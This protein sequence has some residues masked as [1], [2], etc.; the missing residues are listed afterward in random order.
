MKFLLRRRLRAELEN[1]A[2]I[3]RA[4]SSFPPV[5]VGAFKYYEVLR[6]GENHSSWSVVPLLGMRR[7]QRRLWLMRISRERAMNWS[8]SAKFVSLQTLSVWLLRTF[9]GDEN[10]HL[11]ERMMAKW[12]NSAKPVSL[13]GSVKDHVGRCFEHLFVAT[14]RAGSPAE[15]R[16]SH[17]WLLDVFTGKVT[18]VIEEKSG[19][20]L[21]ELG[22]TNDD[23]YVRIGHLSLGCTEQWVVPRQSPGERPRLLWPRSMGKMYSVDH[24]KDDQWLIYCDNALFRARA[25]QSWAS[26]STKRLRTW[27]LQ[28][29]I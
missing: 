15:M 7:Q 24:L 20:F 17:V 6:P 5:V 3:G 21:L 28:M 14:T 12:K 25:G 29:W 9:G 11:V 2:E 8:V 10:Y 13:P 18:L 23:Q 26:P 4:A 27:L 1:A 19:D 16:A 22:V